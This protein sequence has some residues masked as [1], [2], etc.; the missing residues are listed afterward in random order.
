MSDKV[1]TTASTV[2]CPH[3]FPVTFTS[4]AAL[5]VAGHPVVRKIDIAHAVV[6]CTVQQK[7]TS[8]TQSSTSATVQDGGS[9][10]VLASG[11]QTNNGACS[12]VDAT[13]DLM[14]VN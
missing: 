8:V 13:L 2:T 10:V 1:L 12:V 5:T 4:Q 6:A 7:C 3:G 14:E 11:L 9:P